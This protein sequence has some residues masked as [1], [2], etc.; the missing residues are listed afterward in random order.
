M[1]NKYLE[2]IATQKKEKKTNHL[3]YGASYLGTV[4]GAIAGQLVAHPVMKYGT[5]PSMMKL[6]THVSDQIG[7]GSTEQ[8]FIKEHNINAEIIKNHDIPGGPQAHIP[9]DKNIRPTVYGSHNNGIQM[10]ELGH[11]KDM[12]GRSSKSYKLQD[13]ALSLLGIGM[14]VHGI[15]NDNKTEAATGGAI[16]VSPTII[17]EFQANRH[18][19]SAFKKHEGREVANKFIKQIASRNMLHYALPIA[20]VAAGTALA[21]KLL[22]KND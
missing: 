4:G 6:H 18:A 9:F 12:A 15:K 11:I 1:E 20:G 21:T 14:A 19:Y 7:D 8:N 13:N 10:H 17:K 5:V 22:H 3:G 16:S 2:K